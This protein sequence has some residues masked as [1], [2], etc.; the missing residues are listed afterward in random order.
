MRINVET[1]QKLYAVSLMD[2][3][4]VE[5]SAQYVQILTGKTDEQVNRMKVAKFNKLCGRINKAFEMVGKNLQSGKPKSYVWANGRLYK[6]NYDIKLAGK[7]VETATFATDTI[8]NLHLLMATI[9]EPV[10]LTWRGLKVGKREH[11]EIAHDMLKL[12]M[13]HAYQ[14]AVFFLS[15]FQRITRQFDDLF[16]G[17]GNGGEGSGSEFY[18][19]FGWL[20]QA[21]LVSEFENISVSEVWELTTLNFLNDL[22]YL[23]LKRELDAEHEKKIMAKYKH[24]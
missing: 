5:K 13:G 1:F 21:K 10:R 9:A 15:S 16:R 6:L 19:K 11:H 8:G 24:G 7:Y 22:R 17:D 23:K 2:T 4:E 20:Y 18:Q 3:D 14:S 12:D